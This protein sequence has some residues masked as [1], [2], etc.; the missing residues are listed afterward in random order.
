MHFIIRN[1]NLLSFGWIIVI[2]I[3]FKIYNNF[4]FKNVD[5]LLLIILIFL[6]QLIIS[7]LAY[8]IRHKNLKKFVNSRKDMLEQIK[9]TLEKDFF[10][11]VNK[12]YSWHAFNQETMEIAI[13]NEDMMLISFMDNKA[14]IT[15]L[16]TMV[17]YNFYYGKTLN[18]YGHYDKT[19]FEHYDVNHLYKEMFKI[20]D[21]LLGKELILE[22][23]YYLGVLR[24]CRLLADGKEIYSIKDKT[25]KHLR[26]KKVKTQKIVL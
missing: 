25:K 13:G 1:R 5:S 9:Q 14:V 24:G 8:I 20:I 19:G 26:D 2:L 18:G 6:P 4:E 17:R 12:L 15:I 21:L 3:F 10:P 23:Y 16:N 22:N 7:I 11:K